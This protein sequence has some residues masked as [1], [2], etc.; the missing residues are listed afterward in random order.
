[1]GVLRY[2]FA[3]GLCAGEVLRVLKWWSFGR[4]VFVSAWGWWVFGEALLLCYCRYV[5]DCCVF[6]CLFFIYV[7]GILLKMGF[8]R[9]INEI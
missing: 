2:V 1:M 7:K 5:M 4:V 8:S 3:C 9:K 6:V